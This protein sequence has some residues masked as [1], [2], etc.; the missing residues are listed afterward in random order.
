[1]SATLLGHAAQ[2]AAVAAAAASGQLHHAWLLAGPPGIG[3]ASFA[4]AMALRLLA[5]AADPSL[6][7]GAEV[8]PTHPVAVLLANGTHPDYRELRRLPKKDAKK[9]QPTD[10]LARSI[11]VDQ[12]RTL[13][14]FLGT[15]PSLSPRRVI[16]IDTADDLERPGA[17]NALLKNLEEPPAGTVFLLVSNAP[18]RLLPTIRSRCRLLRFEPLGAEDMAA[19]LRRELPEADAGEIDQLVRAGEG[20]PGRA[21]RY[22]GLDLAAIDGALAAI[23][24]DGDPANARRLKLAKALAA[25]A[26]QPRYEAF[27]DRVPTLI[28]AE[29]AQRRGPDLARALDAYGEA[30][31]VAAAARGLSLD[32]SGTVMELAGIV[33]RLAPAP[34][35]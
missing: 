24:R 4:R 5:T 6:R 7:P 10:E 16:V 31:A 2:A 26:A 13:I 21:L 3:K 14:P 27:L 1:M 9:D 11:P 12:V 18:G 34:P 19:V 25:K 30:R 8:P 20:S 15:R 33:A 35:A 23:A 28:A 22:A 29:A 32:A 17:S